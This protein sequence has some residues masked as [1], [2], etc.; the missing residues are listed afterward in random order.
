MGK[1]A[2]NII[3]RARTDELILYVL[4]STRRYYIKLC[5]CMWQVA[6]NILFWTRTEALIL[7]VPPNS[8]DDQHLDAAA[9]NTP[10]GRML[11]SAA[12]RLLKT[13]GTPYALVFTGYWPGVYFWLQGIV[14]FCAW[15]RLLY[16]FRGFLRLGALVH[17]MVLY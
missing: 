7:Y 9:D 8:Y 5:N 6:V 14:M 2:V 16:Y 4:Y 11:G 17:S 3:F 1:L 10:A 12:G 15:T 13:G